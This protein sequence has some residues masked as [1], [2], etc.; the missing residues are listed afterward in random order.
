VVEV[1]VREVCFQRLVRGDSSEGARMMPGPA[2]A[3]VGGTTWRCGGGALLDAQ[4]LR[5][6][7]GREAADAAKRMMMT[8]A[9][10]C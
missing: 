10:H 9:A 2:H 6:S 1:A 5:Q 4:R 7:R 3:R 8:H